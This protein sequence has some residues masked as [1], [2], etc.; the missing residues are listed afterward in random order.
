V[1]TS[2]GTK[3]RQ[4]RRYAARFLPR[5][6]SPRNTNSA[7][8][9][10]DVEDRFGDDLPRIA[11][12]LFPRVTVAHSQPNC[13][14]AR[15]NYVARA[16]LS[17]V[18]EHS[19]PHPAS[20]VKLPLKPMSKEFKTD[21][22]PRRAAGAALVAVALAGTLAQA[23]VETPC[24]D[25]PAGY[26]PAIPQR[27][28]FTAPWGFPVPQDHGDLPSEST[29]TANSST[30]TALPP[31]VGSGDLHAA[32]ATIAGFGNVTIQPETAALATKGYAPTVQIGLAT[33]PSSGDTIFRSTSGSA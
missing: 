23:P 1:S 9:T 20:K 7:D 6:P 25:R 17:A 28:C 30:G 2:T 4:N 26:L 24:E 12:S 33:N 32:E 18:R 15:E 11:G 21:E 5:K 10:V 27:E 3:C 16:D 29:V 8:K 22:L 19:T 14:R 31:V 13:N